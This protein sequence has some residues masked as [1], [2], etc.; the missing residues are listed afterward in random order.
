MTGGRARAP[1]RAGDRQWLSLVTARLFPFL[2][3]CDSGFGQATARHLDIM[4]FQ[5]FASVLDLQSPGAQE[6]RR[7]CSSRLTLLQMDLTK[8]EDIQR[9]LQHIQAHTNSTGRGHFWQSHRTPQNSLQPAWQC[10]TSTCPHRGLHPCRHL[11]QQ[12]LPSFLLVLGTPQFP[13]MSPSSLGSSWESQGG[14]SPFRSP[15][16]APHPH[17]TLGPGEQRWVQ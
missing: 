12:P 5:V 6:L 1:L 13:C 4:G 7:S 16:Q 17:R 11:C 8:T 2:S 14:D 10:L 3:G 15:L 9:V